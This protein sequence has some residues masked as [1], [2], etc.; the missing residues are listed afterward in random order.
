[1]SCYGRGDRPRFVTHR[2]GFTPSWPSSNA[3]PAAT[4]TTIRTQILDNNPNRREVG[5]DQQ[6]CL[7]VL[8]QHHRILID[9]MFLQTPH[10]N[11]S[12]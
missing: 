6:V 10:S 2:L 7:R 5:E 4:M 1:M 12:D 8:A 9:W 11:S 3:V